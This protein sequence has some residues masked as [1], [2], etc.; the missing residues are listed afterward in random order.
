MALSCLMA[1][2]MLRIPLQLSFDEKFTFAT[3]P[4]FREGWGISF[5]EN[6]DT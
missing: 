3:L 4:E 2:L 5:S 1:Q 6:W